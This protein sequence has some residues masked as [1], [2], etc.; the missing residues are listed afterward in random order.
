[1]VDFND[2]CIGIIQAY[3][4][5]SSSSQAEIDQ[6]HDDVLNEISSCTWNMVIGDF[7]A[8]LGYD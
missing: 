6:F 5:T 7:N 4:P 3:A 8:K 1:M 2:K